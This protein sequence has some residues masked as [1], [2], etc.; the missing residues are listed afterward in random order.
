MKLIDRLSRAAAV[1][2][3]WVPGGLL[4]LLLVR[5]LPYLVGYGL[6]SFGLVVVTVGLWVGKWAE[7]P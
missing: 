3:R 2:D 7:R 6:A 1:L 5:Q 4:A